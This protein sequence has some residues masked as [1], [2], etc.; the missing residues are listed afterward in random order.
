MPMLIEQITH[1]E[2]KLRP[3]LSKILPSYFFIAIYTLSRNLYLK[4]LA[5]SAAQMH[6]PVTAT[7]PQKLMSAKLSFT[8]DLG[9]AAGFDKDGTLLEFNYRL[10]AGF[11]VVGTVLPRPHTGN[12]YNFFGRKANPWVPLPASASAI[13]SLGLPNK[14]IEYV[15]KNITSFINKYPDINFPIG[16]SVMGHP[17][18][19]ASEK[20]AG[21][22]SV[23]KQAASTVDFIE[24][25]ESCPNTEVQSD[26]EDFQ[27][28][29]VE[30]INLRNSLES[31]LEKKL[32]IFIKF[33]YI[34][35]P[36]ELLQFLDQYNVDGLVISNT[37]TDYENLAAN[38]NQSDN[39]LYKYY[40]ANYQGGV[41]GQAIKQEVYSLLQKLDHLISSHNYQLKLIHVGGITTKV[42]L[43]QSRQL[44]N[45][46]LREWYTG[47]L[48][49]MG[50]KPW[51]KIYSELLE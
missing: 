36:E 31:R 45:V 4:L 14:G 50:S 49:Q 11:A 32:P 1:F 42:D 33:N 20:L 23:I 5:K 7:T 48:D 46:I 26:W 21:V 39:A 38:L 24:V 2:H 10:G 9:N 3:V 51:S 43:E 17:K 29:V 13:N 27:S 30:I 12:L 47:L 44:T 35:N 37:R 18:D 41:S 34:V 6:Q 15:L 19:D 25:N 40:T 22:L 16:L 28:R 8:N